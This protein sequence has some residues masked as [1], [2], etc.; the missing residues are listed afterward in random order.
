MSQ[1][2]HDQRAISQHSDNEN[3]EKQNRHYVSFRSLTVRYVR[4]TLRRIAAVQE[5]LDECIII[6]TE[7]IVY[8]C[9]IVIQTVVHIG[10]VSNIRSIECTFHQPYE[11]IW[12]GFLGTPTN[13]ALANTRNRDDFFGFLDDERSVTWK[14]LS[15]SLCVKA[16]WNWRWIMYNLSFMRH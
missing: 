12:V 16:E 4:F 3:D 14:K 1:E 7:Q 2:N 8:N 9:L 10:K 11:H 6:G 13:R 5:I 15:I